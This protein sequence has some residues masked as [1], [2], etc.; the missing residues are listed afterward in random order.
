MH[1]AGLIRAFDDAA[2]HPVDELPVIANPIRLQHDRQGTIGYRMSVG[3][4]CLA[5]KRSGALPVEPLASL[6]YA[7]DLGHAPPALIQHF[8]G[9][10]I[11]CIEANYDV[12]M[13]VNSP[14]P[15]FVNRRNLSDSGHLSNEQAF[16]AACRIADASPHGNPRSVVLL[17]RSSQCNHPM[18]L[19]RVFERD[20]VLAR[21]IVLSE[22]RRRTRWVGVTPRRAV[23]RRQMVLA[24][25]GGE[26]MHAH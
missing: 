1:E 12:N 16:D 22:Q 5:A 9:V 7:T 15:S 11:L 18:K 21:R 6:G 26:G 14:R 13:T 25:R 19:R 10:D 2:F 4:S 24:W 20:P 23:Q 17:H 8:A 3:A